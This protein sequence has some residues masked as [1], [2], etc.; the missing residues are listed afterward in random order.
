MRAKAFG[1][2]REDY[3]IQFNLHTRLTSTDPL[4]KIEV[5]AK[6]CAA[7]AV[8]LLGASSIAV[9]QGNYEIGAGDMLHVIVLDQPAMSGDFPVDSEGMMSF[10]F[11]GK[12]K[13]AGMAPAEVERKLA[14]LLSEGYLRRPKVSVSVK[15]YGSQ[16]VYVTGEFQKPGPYALGAD[17]SLLSLLSAVGD[18]T[19]NAGHEIIVI[20]PPKGDLLKL[21]PSSDAAPAAEPSPPSAAPP[22]PGEVPGSDVFRI[23]LRELRSGYPEKNIL[24]EAKDTVYLP[25]A[26]QIYVLGYVAKPGPYRYEEGLTVYQALLQAGGVSDRGS[27][28][29]IKIIRLVEGK[30]KEFK[31]K[32]TDMLQPEDTIKVPERFF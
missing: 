23:N 11:L 9:A 15:E 12:V 20:R 19:P 27:Q 30:T 18:V 25:K 5:M 24:L 4:T 32:L 13:A 10:P 2:A 3:H 17:R 8:A 28:G 29:G 21:D 16:R 7:L 31:P 14:T 26:A 22:L 6:V 1:L